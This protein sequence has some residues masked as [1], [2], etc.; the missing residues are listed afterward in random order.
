MLL[1]YW[2]CRNLFSREPCPSIWFISMFTYPIT[3]LWVSSNT[4]SLALKNDAGDSVL[5]KFPLGITCHPIDILQ[6]SNIRSLQLIT[7]TI[8]NVEGSTNKELLSLARYAVL[9]LPTIVALTL[10]IPTDKIS[11]RKSPQCWSWTLDFSLPIQ[12]ITRGLGIPSRWVYD[13]MNSIGVRW[14]AAI[15]GTRTL[16]WT[17]EKYWQS[18]R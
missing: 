5:L 3:N 18:I 16:T 1:K 13:N 15:N 10:K 17:D 7:A 4:P 8:Q 2:Q 14:N 9:K 6:H 11:W 12:K